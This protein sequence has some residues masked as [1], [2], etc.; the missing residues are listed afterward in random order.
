MDIF[1]FTCI[2]HGNSCKQTVQTQL[3]PHKLQRLNWVGTVAYVPKIGTSL[4]RVNKFNFCFYFSCSDYVSYKNFYDQEVGEPDLDQS[5][6]T[7]AGKKKN[8]Y[9]IC[10]GPVMK[11]RKGI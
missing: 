9:R 8:L 2:L 3:R 11:W 1:T 5:L 7:D 10:Y 4:I 6:I